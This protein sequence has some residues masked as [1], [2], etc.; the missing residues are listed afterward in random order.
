MGQHQLNVLLA[1]VLQ[2]PTG[3]QE[4]P[5]RSGCKATQHS[6]WFEARALDGVAAIGTVMALT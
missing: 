6:G 2:R 3:L 5:G 1:D 4:G